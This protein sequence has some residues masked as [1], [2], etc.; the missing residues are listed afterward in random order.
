MNSEHPQAAKGENRSYKLRSKTNNN[1]NCGSAIE[2][3]LLSATETLLLN[4]L[5]DKPLV[6]KLI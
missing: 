6:D 3:T 1:W 4:R 2:Q 5:L